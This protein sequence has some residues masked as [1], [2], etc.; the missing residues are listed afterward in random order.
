[1]QQAHQTNRRRFFTSLAG[2]AT[3]APAVL[4]QRNRRPNVLFILADEW[5]AQST[6]YNGDSN[7]R[8]PVLDR[9]AGQSVSF[10]IAVSSTPVCCPFRASLMTGQYPLTNGVF[11]N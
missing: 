2:A 10:D 4:G 9:L 6:G 3:A 7:V 1:M 8:A 5:R 11:I